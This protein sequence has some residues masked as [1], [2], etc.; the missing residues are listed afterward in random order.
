MENCGIFTMIICT[1]CGMIAILGAALVGLVLFSI[2][3]RNTLSENL[4]KALDRVMS[5]DWDEF[6]KD[7][8]VRNDT[9][10]KMMAATMPSYPD[11]RGL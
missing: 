6:S 5:A 8:R 7:R 1:L 11:E 4:N 3:E 2:K 9:R 10:L